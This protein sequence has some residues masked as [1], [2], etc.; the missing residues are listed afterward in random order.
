[1][2]CSDGVD[3]KR[4]RWFLLVALASVP[5]FAQQAPG[6]SG[7][8][9]LTQHNDTDRTGWN[10]RETTLTPGSV[11]AA[12]FGK[13]FDLP[14]DGLIYAQ[15]LVVSGVEING[16]RRDIVV[17]ATQHNSVYVFDA[18]TGEQLWRLH[19]GP[20]IP[21]PNRFWNTAWGEYLDL[22]QE[23]GI[24]STPVID[25]DTLTLYFTS[26]T[27]SRS[28]ARETADE[29]TWQNDAEAPVVNYHLHAVDLRTARERPGAPIRIEGSVPVI[30]SHAGRHDGPARLT[31]NPMQHLQRAALLQTHNR[32]V[33]AFGSHADQAPYQGW[34]F[35]Y[36]TRD[37]AAAPWVWSSMA[38]GAVT[39][40]S[41][42][43][44]WQA[45]MGLTADAAGNVYLVTGN[46]N[47]DPSTRQY[48]DAVVKLSMKGAISVADYFSP[49]NQACLESSD[50]DLG[51][52]GVLRLPGTNLF[53]LGGKPGRLFLLDGANLGKFSPPPAARCAS[54]CS[55][56]RVFSCANPNV[57]QEFQ[58]GCDVA[59]NPATLAPPTPCSSAPV[60]GHPP[61]GACPPLMYQMV[62]HH[63][64]GSPVYWRGTRRG[65][66]VYV[67]AEN[68]VIRAFPFDAATRRFTATGCAART[69][70]QAWTVGRQV[71]PAALHFGMTGGMLS[72][73]SSAGANG[74][75]WAVTPTNNDSNQR[76][77]PGILRA[78]DANDLRRELWNSYQVRDRDDFGNF[79]KHA[80]PTVANGKVYV[81]TFSGH[82]SVYGLKPREVLS[83]PTLVRDGDFEAGAEGWTI[84]GP[85]KLNDAY[86]YWGTSAATLCPLPDRDGRIWQEIIAPQAGTYVLTA[87]AATNIRAG[88]VP[89]GA[90]VETVSLGVDV[91][92]VFVRAGDRIPPFAGYQRQT[93]EFAASAGSRIRV[94][95]RAPKAAPLPF[96]GIT[97]ARASRRPSRP[98]TA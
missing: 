86:P 51:S 94:W 55:D 97:P 67:W 87:Y 29:R 46:G 89:P 8:D 76:V 22:T 84:D 38:G 36:D 28:V 41:G 10:P 96:Y 18:E 49:C 13:I 78:Y 47:F 98:S 5:M 48:G 45:G 60:M 34:V 95:F 33:L 12:T 7:V 64:H 90:A 80:P 70:A 3:V 58:A 1:V 62:G 71:S 66:A 17:V 52:S 14:V 72:I 77:V 79:S 44:I 61:P 40:M 31:F 81:P 35:A 85:A 42:S 68:D 59:G 65:A 11:A 9:V 82:L 24:T 30:P 73:S 50:G 93:I 75:V 83:P 74:I 69:P 19:Y 63:I 27:W 21:T 32:V 25:R 2:E 56:P 16:T 39:Q 57:L 23:V 54:P 4:Y 92:G 91:D 20:S 15:P 88:N 53:L 26:V 6:P 43:G 37:L